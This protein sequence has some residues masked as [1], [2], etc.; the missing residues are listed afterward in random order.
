MRGVKKKKTKNSPKAETLHCC[1]KDLCLAS[2]AQNL[3]HLRVAL[4]NMQMHVPYGIIRGNGWVLKQ[5]QRVMVNTQSLPKVGH[6][7]PPIVSNIK[8]SIASI[9]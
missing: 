9:Q 6:P 8:H 4:T 1:L 5:T 3:H 7:D 2:G